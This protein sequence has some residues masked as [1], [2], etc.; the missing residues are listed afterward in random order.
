MTV[1]ITIVA[2]TTALNTAA[3]M[4][5]ATFAAISGPMPDA[6][7]AISVMG[8]TIAIATRAA[9][10]TWT[11]DTSA[12]VTTAAISAIVNTDATT[13][14][15]IRGAEAAGGSGD[16]MQR[17]HE[18]VRDDR[19]VAEQWVAGGTMPDPDETWNVPM[20]D[21]D[22]TWPLRALP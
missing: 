13:G 2:I 14:T 21:L 16:D 17:E 1:L 8:T 18:E 7:R 11:A 4:I 15:T 3:T 6:T 22:A 20:E 10:R 9:I 12:S 19:E 5:E